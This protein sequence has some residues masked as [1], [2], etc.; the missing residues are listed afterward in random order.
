M[1]AARA[2]GPEEI[3][4][5]GVNGLLYPPG[6]VAALARVL[7][8]LAEDPALRSRL[9]ERGRADAARSLPAPVAAAMTAFYQRVLHT[10]EGHRLR[11]RR[12]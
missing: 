3:V 9:G 10:T 2:G 11:S 7:R 8:A 4:T 1:V 12:R 6:D 5:D